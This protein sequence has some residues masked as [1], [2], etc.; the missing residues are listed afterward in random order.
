M[1]LVARIRW[2]FFVVY[3]ALFFTT[4]L[5]LLWELPG[6]GV[7]ATLTLIFLY[8]IRLDG[9][10]RIAQR[11]NVSRLTYAEAP[12]LHAITEEFCRRLKISKPSLDILESDA[13]N[14]AQFGFSRGTSHLVISR[15][16]LKHLKPFELSALIA[17]ELTLLR[18]GDIVGGSWLSQFLSLTDS[19]VGLPHRST[20]LPARREY[21]FEL[22]AKQILIYPLTLIPT[23]LLRSRRKPGRID[24]ESLKLSRRPEILAEALRFADAMKERDQLT[25]PFSTRHLFLIAPPTQDPLT[26]LFFHSEELNPRVLSLEKLK[27]VLSST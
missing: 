9:A 10:K 19:L 4:P 7:G 24:F 17:R 25:V 14:L 23:I 16:A 22:V 20:D 21:S 1:P 3:I 2:I 8:W 6:A 27:V 26:R 12:K 13:I 18:Y 5:W 11:L 15:G